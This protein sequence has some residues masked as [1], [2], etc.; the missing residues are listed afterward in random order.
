M[1]LVHFPSINSIKLSLLFI[2]ISFVNHEIEKYSQR[3]KTS[4]T[5]QKLKS[6]QNSDMIK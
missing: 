1:R 6:K 5:A 3:S 4:I 2:K